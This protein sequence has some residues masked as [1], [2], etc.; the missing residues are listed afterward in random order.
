MTKPTK[1]REA[2]PAPVDATE[3]VVIDDAPKVSPA[4]RREPESPK[5]EG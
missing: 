4:Q 5:K 3:T 2:V 1:P